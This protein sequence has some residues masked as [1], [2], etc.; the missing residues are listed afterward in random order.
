MAVFIFHSWS[1]NAR[2]NVDYTESQRPEGTTKVHM[3]K[4]A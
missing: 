4:T 3:R 1:L 2:L